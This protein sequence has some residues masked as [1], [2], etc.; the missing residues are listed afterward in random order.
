MP[1]THDG[2]KI[3]VAGSLEALSR[4]VHRNK[5]ALESLAQQ[6]E[7][8]GLVSVVKTFRRAGPDPFLLERVGRHLLSDAP[9]ASRSVST[10]GRKAATKRSSRRSKAR[11]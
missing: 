5:M 7:A 2:Y 1:K 6:L 11:R 9:S 8:R 4:Q 3:D 10:S